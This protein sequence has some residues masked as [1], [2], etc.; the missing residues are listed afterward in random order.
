MGRS[1]NSK[2]DEFND[3]IKQFENYTAFNSSDFDHDSEVK[4]LFSFY[5]TM[6]K[7]KQKNDIQLKKQLR[8]Y[9]LS[10][11]TNEFKITKYFTAR[12]YIKEDSENHSKHFNEVQDGYAIQN[13]LKISNHTLAISLYDPLYYELEPNQYLSP[14]TKEQLTEPLIED[15]P[16]EVLR[17]KIKKWH[18]YSIALDKAR[19]FIKA[20][21]PSWSKLDKGQKKIAKAKLFQLIKEL[22]EFGTDEY[23][24]MAIEDILNSGTA[25][26]Q[27]YELETKKL[28]SLKLPHITSLQK[29]QQVTQYL[30]KSSI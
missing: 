6:N 12:K 13:I 11:R 2:E 20:R 27:L 25:L 8:K 23:S 29:A 1:L 10:D 16:Q 24:I 4:E 22:K 15:N 28:L 5:L 17:K 26:N 18:Q 7:Y 14:E 9:L 3:Y 21:Y 19:I 30:I